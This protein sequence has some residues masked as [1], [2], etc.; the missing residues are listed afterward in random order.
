MC[1]QQCVCKKTP[2]KAQVCVVCDVQLS[3]AGLCEHTLGR[4][5]S[6]QSI[7]AWQESLKSTVYAFVGPPIERFIIFTIRWSSYR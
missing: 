3:A 4:K 2:Q 7:A 6:K 5:N 1:M